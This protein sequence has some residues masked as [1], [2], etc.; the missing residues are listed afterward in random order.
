MSEIQYRSRRAFALENEHLEVI[1]TVEGGHIAALRDKVTGVNPL[2][3]PPW[4]SIEPSTYERAKHPEY[5]DDA[6][7]KLLSGI[8][9]HNLCL[10]LFGAPS[11]EE[12]AAGVSVHGEASIASYEIRVSPGLLVQAATLRQSQLG[13]ERSI[14]LAPG[15]R[16]V[17][18]SETVRNLSPWDRPVAW[19]Q[20][21]TLGPPFLEAGKTEFRCSATKSKVYEGKF[22]EH[23]NMKAG[24]EF[25]WPNVPVKTGGAED[26][27]TYTNRPVS[28]GFT[29]HLMDASRE[30]AFFA[31]WSPSLQLQISYEWRRADFPWLGIWEENH[32]RTAPPWRGQTLTRGME[33]G[34]SPFPESRRQMITRG[35][36]FGVPAYLW[37]PGGSQKTVNYAAVVEPA[38]RIREY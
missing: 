30:D 24:A 20:H 11:E 5:G 27:R 28:G 6:E 15:S 31:A 7:S 13:F 34:V 3:S 9:G 4:A 25:D 36:L 29:T 33:F 32:G 17:E 19:T 16:R 1:V 8:L 26:L 14:R 12:A 38:S 22:G 2:W 35:T 23:G 21:A 18:I 10:D 37:L